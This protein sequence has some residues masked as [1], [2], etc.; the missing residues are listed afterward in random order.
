MTIFACVFNGSLRRNEGYVHAYT[1]RWGWMIGGRMFPVRRTLNFERTNCVWG[2]WPSSLPP[3]MCGMWMNR[4]SLCMWLGWSWRLLIKFDR[5]ILRLKI[6]VVVEEWGED[7]E[8]EKMDSTKLVASFGWRRWRQSFYFAL[9]VWWAVLM[10]VPFF[11]FVVRSFS[12]ILL[13]SRS[14]ICICIVF[15]MVHI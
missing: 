2:Q 12:L 1:P 14:R 4:V 7:S 11:Y 8:G 10:V 13:N 5:F 6:R 3:N 9:W 15:I